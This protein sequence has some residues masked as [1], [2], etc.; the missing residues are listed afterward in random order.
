MLQT[1]NWLWSLIEAGDGDIWVSPGAPI[2]VIIGAIVIFATNL[3]VASKEVEQVRQEA[4]ERIQ[5][6]DIELHPERVAREEKP[7][8]PFDDLDDEQ[9]EL[10]AE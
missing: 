1:T 6:D 2:L 7:R 8:S 5:Q 9:I 10:H 3:A 4:P